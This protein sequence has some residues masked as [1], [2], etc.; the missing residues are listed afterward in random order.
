MY[1][2]YY[3]FNFYFN[4]FGIMSINIDISNIAN[5]ANKQTEL[6]TNNFNTYKNNLIFESNC[7]NYLFNYY[8][9]IWR[10]LYSIDIILSLFVFI[11]K[12]YLILYKTENEFFI[13]ILSLI[14]SGLTSLINSIWIKEKYATLYNNHLLCY[15]HV[16][17]IINDMNK[18]IHNEKI[19]DKYDECDKSI[20][21]YYTFIESHNIK[22]P[23][24]C[25][26][27]FFLR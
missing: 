25:K 22:I 26:Y 10:F 4:S 9:C 17:D 21:S 7:H 1:I 5:I 2:D 16:S 23:F 8:L 15:N 6:K 24:W 20:K 3:F 27:K 11:V 12:I 13:L 18:V 19:L 14:M